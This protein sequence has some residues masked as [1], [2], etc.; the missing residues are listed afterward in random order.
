[1]NYNRYKDRKPK[2]TITKAK[3]LLKK[4]NL[5]AEE[6]IM[7]N[8]LKNLYSC[9][10]K[11][12]SLL[13]DVNGKGTTEEYCLASGYGELLERL[14]NF[15][16][17]KFYITEYKPINLFYDSKEFL[18]NTDLYN[19]PKS[20]INDMNNSF[21]DSDGKYPT[22]QNLIEVYQKKFGSN[23][24]FSIPFYSSKNNNVIHLPIEIIKEL[25][26]S[27]G[28]SCGNTLEEATSQAIFE[29]LER[30]VYSNIYFNKLTPPQIPLEYIF[31]E[32]PNLSEVIKSFITSEYDITFYDGSL[33][34]GFPVVG[35]ILVNKKNHSYKMNFGSHFS[36]NIAVERCLTEIVQG[37]EN[38]ELLANKMCPLDTFTNT[39]TYNNFYNL[40]VKAVGN[41]PMEFFKKTP[42]WIFKKWKY[43]IT[44]KS[45]KDICKELINF[46]LLHSSDVYI[47]NNSYMDFSIVHVY[48]PNLSPV[49]LATPKGYNSVYSTEQGLIITGYNNNVKI[50]NIDEYKN[51]FKLNLGII[52]TQSR[53]PQKLL[54]ASSY[55]DTKDYDM[56]ITT[57]KDIKDS[58]DYIKIIIHILELKKLN[59]KNDDI[60]YILEKFYNNKDINYAHE[61]LSGSFLENILNNREF[62]DTY[63][64]LIENNIKTFIQKTKKFKTYHQTNQLDTNILIK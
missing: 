29:F 38:Y 27:N 28:L 57:L 18:I 19:I 64:T 59:Y 49:K 44:G 24:I 16:F 33:D 47:R 58:P 9:H 2:D 42:S 15:C 54:L 52:D 34:C 8:P 39:H 41:V 30:Y 12:P 61:L 37:I 26:G 40:Y 60:N 55:Y 46:C 7:F 10:I 36:F 35:I 20:I 51:I 1:M 3:T 4:F 14:L 21:V 62:N 25:T 43:N 56:C 48:I 23:K 11:I 22:I 6:T 5:L 32:C 17:R 45:N 53:I 31:Q 13:L 50:N 63:F